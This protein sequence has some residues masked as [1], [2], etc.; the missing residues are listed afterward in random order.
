MD[1]EQV[2][3]I[4]VLERLSKEFAVRRRHLSVCGLKDKQGRTAP[5]VGVLVG[6]LGESQVVQ[7]GDLRL[8]LVGRTAQP[9]SS[10]NISANR[11][12]GTVRDLSPGAAPLGREGA[13][14]W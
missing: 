14:E 10:A 3:T 6:A 8:K 5:L 1:K 4:Q 12:E 13:A 9:L 2:S 11:F 7:S